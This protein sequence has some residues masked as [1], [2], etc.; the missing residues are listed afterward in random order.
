M[1]L[2][3]FAEQVLYSDELSRKITRITESLT[4][5]APGAAVRV[6]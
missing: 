4:D 5:H 6:T 3:G 2:R 1:E